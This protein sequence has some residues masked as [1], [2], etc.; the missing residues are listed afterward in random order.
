MVLRINTLLKMST[1][2]WTGQT[3][4]SFRDFFDNERACLDD[5]TG[6]YTTA[7]PCVILDPTTDLWNMPISCEGTGCPAEFMKKFRTW[8]RETNEWKALMLYGYMYR[9]M[10]GIESPLVSIAPAPSTY[11]CTDPPVFYVRGHNVDMCASHMDLV[12]DYGI[13]ASAAL[14]CN[15][16]AAVMYTTLQDMNHLKRTEWFPY[17]SHIQ[18]FC[19]SDSTI[20]IVII[21]FIS[22][23]GFL[24][25]GFIAVCGKD[26]ERRGRARTVTSR[27]SDGYLYPVAKLLQPPPSPY[28]P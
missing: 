22:I 2:S 1:V 20:N 24:V 26:N 23:I 27:G 8:T 10:G 4:V 28:S 14:A 3:E 17:V 5:K 13:E 21:T 6:L 12:W 18:G 7:H 16:T 19:A 15:D 9:V 25:I 11:T